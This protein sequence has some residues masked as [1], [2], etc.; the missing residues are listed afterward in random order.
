MNFDVPLLL[1]GMIFSGIGFVYFSYGK[2]MQKFN[3]MASG[4]VLMVCPYFTENM[5]STVIVGLILSALPF[6]LKWW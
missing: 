5:V 3:L 2:R 6:L 1:V 4:L